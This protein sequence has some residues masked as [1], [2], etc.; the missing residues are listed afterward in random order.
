MGMQRW[1]QTTKDQFDTDT[2]NGSAAS[3]SY[4]DG[5]VELLGLKITYDTFSDLEYT[6]NPTWTPYFGTWSAANGYL[7]ATTA[8]T[9]N[10]ISTPVTFNPSYGYCWEDKFK[11]ETNS[12]AVYYRF[13]YMVNNP[14]PNQVTGTN[15]YYIE[16]R[17][18]GTVQFYRQDGSGMASLV[19]FSWS[20]DPNWHV[21]KGCR[22]ASGLWSIYFDGSLKGTK[23]DT[24]Y[25]ASNFIGFRDDAP[26]TNHNIYH[27]NIYMN[28]TDAPGTA[29]TNPIIYSNGPSGKVSWNALTWSKDI[30]YGTVTVA[31]QKYASS[32]VWTGIQVSTSPIS[33]TSLGTTMQVRL[34]ANLTYAGGSPKLLDWEVSW[35]SAPSP[36]QNLAASPGNKKIT[37]TWGAPLDD[38]GSTI[39]AYRLFRGTSPGGE[40]FLIMLSGSTLPCVDYPLK[41]GVIYYYKVNARNSVGLGSMSNEASGKPA[42]EPNS[43]RTLTAS[44]G[45]SNVTLHWLQPINDGG[46]PVTFYK[47]YRSPDGISYAYIDSTSFLTYLNTGLTNGFKYYY[48]VSAVNAMGE[49]AQSTA[50]NATPIGPPSYPGGLVASAGLEKVTITW[51]APSSNG[52]ANVTSYK[53]YRGISISVSFYVSVP[54][55]A[56]SYNDTLVTP[57]TLY[58]YEM[59]AVNIAGEGSRGGT[60]TAIPY[61]YPSTPRNLVATS[62]SGSIALTW[63]ASLSDG[64]RT[65]FSYDILRGTSP[66]DDSWYV[67]VPGGYL[68][69]VDT[70]VVSG[71]VYYYHVRAV[72]DAGYSPISNEANAT[73]RGTPSPPTLVSA[74]GSSKKVTLTWTIPSSNG[75]SPITS[76]QIWRGT[77]PG[78][79]TF[80]ISVS[81]SATS[82]TDWWATPG[83]TYYYKV[84]AVTAAGPGDFSDEMSAMAT[85]NA[86]FSIPPDNGPLFPVF[87]IVALAIL[88][89]T[90]FAMTTRRITPRR[91]SAGAT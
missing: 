82:G 2:M 8:G 65:I 86:P 88:I 75:G 38:G 29:T 45:N 23:G 77:T 17:G 52:G 63:N 69:Y 56:T 50:A 91:A 4:G 6:T 54:A 33:L 79:E 26:T 11:F 30:T 85:A 16:F 39:N 58:Y 32:W 68:S 41:N 36:P 5:S 12:G 47:I 67:T 21:S 78:G 71:T 74:V 35:L 87:G 43:P 55:I 49:G 37:L 59:S 22:D 44:P 80:L 19:T 1:F 40:R 18:T 84:R 72:N 57:G 89:T 34:V 28:R 70:S 83:V 76:Y 25:T 62:G 27:D 24:T 10:R 42:K 46:S 3:A 61:T 60:S 90:A 7:E 73:A 9:G 51:T 14:D 15:G 53:I 31:V 48:K 66:G 64:G 20:G 13:Y 81:G